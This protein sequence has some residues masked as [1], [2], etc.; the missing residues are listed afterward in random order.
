M[1][2]VIV[3]MGE[4][5][6]SVAKHL[7]ARG[8]TF[9]IADDNP[10]PSRMAELV[11]RMPAAKL[12]SPSE[13]QFQKGDRVIVSP[14]VPLSSDSMQRAI[15]SDSWLTNDVEMFAAEANAPIIGVT[16]SNGKSTVTSMIGAMA[17]ASLDRVGIGG[18]LGTPC[19][20]LLTL[21][22]ELYVI[23]LSS[24]QL[25]LA[26]SLDLEVAVL[27][28][29]APDHLDRYTSV[30]SYYAAKANIFNRSQ[31]AVMA[32][33]LGYPIA[34][35]AKRVLT[36]GAD[37]A[38]SDDDYGLTESAGDILLCRG[39]QTLASLAEFRIKGRHNALNLLAALAAGDALGLSL[40]DM[41]GALKEF[42]GLS[43][44]CEWLGD[45]GGVTWINDSKGTN[46]AATRTAI[47]SLG[48]DCNIVLILGGLAKDADFSLLN[49]A[50]GSHVKSVFVFGSDQQK[51][52]SAISHRKVALCEDLE[53]AVNNAG[54]A[55]ES[56]DVVLFSPACSSLDAYRN[57]AER[58]DHFR[59]LVGGQVL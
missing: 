46:V 41:L 38:P 35:R 34:P 11:F 54:S 6:F 32:R 50:L 25:E 48:D 4:T 36:F 43:H 40:D 21:N 55:A 16:G 7:L 59:Q 9:V 14:G 53:D 18:N 27:L 12:L 3:G 10:A 24:Y 44:R 31:T 2:T 5:G 22:A 20:D 47:E 37:P 19:L 57:F 49:D 23:E 33:G 52:A 56:G 45:S 8:E 30:S 58:G 29:L 42:N 39:E 17:S 13:L 1:E 26:R 28:N 15:A 51:I